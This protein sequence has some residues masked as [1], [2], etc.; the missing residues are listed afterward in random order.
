MKI[1]AIHGLW[2]SSRSWNILHK[3]F[4]DDTFLTPD[5]D[6]SKFKYEKLEEQLLSFGPNILIGH[7]YGGYIVQKLLEK[8]PTVA[9]LCVLIAPVGPKGINFIS[10][11]KLIKTFPVEFIKGLVTGEFRTNNRQVVYRLMGIPDEIFEQYY[12]Y[13]REEK[14]KSVV[15][16]FPFFGNIKHPILI[17]ALVI[18]GGYDMFVSKRDVDRIAIFHN[19]NHLHFLNFG[20]G[21]LL[22]DEVSIEIKKWI[23]NARE[24]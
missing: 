23:D 1:M 18:S 15:R 21:L 2:G 5:I 4:P 14:R 6:W 3:Q 8:N 12:L 10:F 7:S 22:T 13:L 24:W 9:K 16:G 20:H 19:A 11:F 17:P